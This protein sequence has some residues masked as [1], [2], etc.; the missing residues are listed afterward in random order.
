MSI[1]WIFFDVGSTLVNEDRAHK[2]RF[3]AVSGEI[4]RISGKDISFEEFC[5]IMTEGAGRGN[6]SPFSYALK[7]FGISAKIPYFPDGE[8]PYPEAADVLAKLK[9]RYKLGVIANQPPC[10]DGR[11]KSYGLLDY[12][13]ALFG[14]GDVGLAKPDVEFYKYAI[15]A[16]GCSPAEAVMIG[17]RLDND[18]YPAKKAGMKT[19][20]LL[21][22]FFRTAEPASKEEMPDFTVKTL[23]ELPGII[24]KM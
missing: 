13:D 18:V 4:K 21:S 3:D 19:I 5:D 7:K 12:F 16:V 9:P 22:S 11:L 17:D 20:R 14:S 6:K 24:A 10:L 23:S 1:K 8:E 2:A 15:N